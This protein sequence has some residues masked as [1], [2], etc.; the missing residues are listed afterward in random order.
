MIWGLTA[1]E[2]E[3][4][5]LIA[6]AQC[7]GL[8]VT[9]SS[10]GSLKTWDYQNSA[11]APVLVHAKELKMKTIHC[12]ELCPDL[13]FVVASGGENKSNNFTVLDLRSIDPGMYLLNNELNKFFIK[14]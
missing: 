1:H 5:G 12:L 2:Q 6:S 10:D 11:Q 13:P 7:K 8:L 3:I 9:T 14:M 4:T